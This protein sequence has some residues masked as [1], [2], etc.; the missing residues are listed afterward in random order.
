MSKILSD[1]NQLESSPLQDEL[2]KTYFSSIPS[3]QERQIKKPVQSKKYRLTKKLIL[4][5]SL[6]AVSILAVVIFLVLNR[7]S[8]DIQI[9]PASLS[10]EDTYAQDVT[11]IKKGAELNT[12]L[13]KNVIFFENADGRSTWG[14]RF[15]ILSNEIPSKK[16]AM[17]I[18]FNNPQNL[19][20]NILCFYARGRL[21]KEELRISLKDNAKGFCRSKING[22]RGG[23]QK[24]AIDISGVKNLI[25]AEN[26][27]RV[28]FELN[29][30]EKQNAYISKVH[31][32][33]IYLCK[34]RE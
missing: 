21:G 13:I 5:I 6:S 24:F 27:T 9:T 2:A 14:N 17:G 15:V 3:A 7:I 29:P 28:D 22:L 25:D 20:G 12:D 31:L 30:A 18:D 26:V 34:R 10:A 33:D 11:Y 8:I 16:A 32:R 1:L 4:T 23:W 19:S